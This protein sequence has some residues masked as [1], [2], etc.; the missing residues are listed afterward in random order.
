MQVELRRLE[1][2]RPYEGNPRQNDAAVDAV[3]HSIREFG[4]RVPIVVDAEGVIICGHTR[5]KAAQKLGLERAPVHVATDL[6]PEKVKAYRIADNRA[7]ELS[8]WDLDLLPIE[9]TELQGMDID[10]ESLGFKPAELEKLL[11]A[12]TY[13]NEGLT[14]PNE[15]PEPPEEP[16]A[17]PGDLWILGG[18]RLLCGDATQA[19]TYDR[20]LEGERAGMM[21]TDPPW[22]VAIGQ[23]SNPRHRQR[24]GLANDALDGDDFEAFLESFIAAAGPHVTGDIYCVLADREMPRLCRLMD[25]HGY[26]LSGTIVW[27]KDSF[28]LTRCNYHRRYEPIWYG[29]HGKSKSS[30]CGRRDLDDVWEVPRPKRSEEHPTMKPVDLV[31]RALVNSSG[32]EGLVLEPFCGSGSTLIACEKTGRRCRAVELE[33]RYIDVIVRRWEEFTGLKAERIAATETTP[34]E[35]GVASGG[36]G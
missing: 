28:V 34:T 15:V 18:H 14:D 25:A 30:F 19:D 32:P 35:A 13:G 10:L 7:A 1:D 16:V 6:S 24:E 29:W 20:L 26:H 27:V 31:V 21:F 3:A 22:N 33:P 4:F 12:G 23:D 17:Q 8:D 9:L 11:G 36:E 5:W 2:I